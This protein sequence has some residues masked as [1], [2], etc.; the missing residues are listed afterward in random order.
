MF[1]IVEG[2]TVTTPTGFTAGA[3]AAGIK[4]PGRLDVGV[5]ASTV[6]AV[7]AGVFTRNAVKSAAVQVSES[8]VSRG[9][10]RAVIANS[11]CANACTG[12]RGIRDA[13][14]L[15]QMVADKVEISAEDV[16]VASTGV[17]G[18]FLPLDRIAPSITEL[19]LG[20]HNGNQFAN[21]I[22]TTD[23]RPKQI[24]ISIE[25]GET[26]IHIG[27]AAKGS[28]MIHPNMGT[29]LCF[30]TTDASVDVTFL[31]SALRRCVDSTLNMVSIDGD[32]SPSDTLLV[33]AN[34]LA[35]NPP[36]DDATGTD[37]EEGLHYVCEY[38]A[39]QIAADGEGAT[40][41][42]EVTVAGAATEDDARIAARTV[43]ASPLVKTAIHGAD[44]N[45]GRIVC[46]VGRSGARMEPS[47]CHLS[48]NGVPVMDKG[49]PLEFAED[50]LRE[51][52]ESREVALHVN[53]GLGSASATAWGCDLSREYVTINASYTT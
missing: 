9:I 29:M 17:I 19:S 53:L 7:T 51:S 32:T 25:C 23:T 47:L 26:P 33:I 37:F 30:I 41:L 35:G 40:K 8:R 22:M 15:A 43:A 24:A 10:A 12:D 36:I 21:A 48:L 50:E 44:P 16:L 42:I 1:T 31:Q 45:W 28:G 6:P 20:P 11:G 39:R 49:M 52:L 5:V 14:S 27:A 18:T 13:L 3:A 46:A 38:I 4:Y 2:G 34:G